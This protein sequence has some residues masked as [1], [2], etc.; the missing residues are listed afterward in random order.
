MHRRVAILHAAVMPR[1]Q[2]FSLRVKNRS[3]NR[4]ASFGQ[5]IAGFRQRDS[6]HCGMVQLG[7][8]FRVYARN[9]QAVENELPSTP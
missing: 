7:H 4:N 6:E 8:G 2:H 3:A 9:R 5:T 1:A